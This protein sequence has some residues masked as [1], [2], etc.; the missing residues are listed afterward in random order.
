MSKKAPVVD[1]VHVISNPYNYIYP[2]D[3][4]VRSRLEF[5]SGLKLGFMMHWAPVTQLGTMES[6]PLSDEDW[7]WSQSE[8]DWTDIEHFKQQYWELPRSFNPVKFAPEAWA[9]LADE[10]GFKYLLFTTKHHDG[11]CM[12]D[13]QWSDYKITSPDCPFH[14]HPKADIVRSLYDAFRARGLAIGTYFSK[15]DWHSPYFWAPQFGP[16]PSR[17]A[18][19]DPAEHPELWEKYVEYT[20]RQLTEL[21]TN[22]GPIDCLWLDGGWVQPSI[23]HQ[24]IRLSELAVKLRAVQPHLV[25]VDR[26]VTG[27]N[28]NILTPEQNVPAAAITVPWESCITLGRKFS[29]HFNDVY[30]SPQ[31]VVHLF[32]EILSKGGSLALNVTPQPNGELPQA[33]VYTLRR[34]GRWVKAHGEAIYQSTFSPCRPER[35]LRYTRRAG[36]DYAFVLYGDYPYLPPTQFAA[37]EAGR[38]VRALRCLRTGQTLPFVQDERGLRIDTRELSMLEADYAECFEIDYVEA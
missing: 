11:F 10:C 28:E 9:R 5:Y 38:K 2:E 13:S 22:Y 14:R 16:A 15:P 33:A 37:C 31:E 26:G 6:W 8:I 27:E 18:N 29:Y 32:I 21:C 19:Y 23:N 35:N 20:H 30:K 1:G 3:P 7:A 25:I 12:Y 17:N 24:D 4:K 34:F 36:R